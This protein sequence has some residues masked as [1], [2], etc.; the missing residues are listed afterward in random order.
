MTLLVNEQF[1]HQ[2]GG[3]FIIRFDDTTPPLPAKQ[4]EEIRLN[5]KETIEWLGIPVDEWEIESDILSDV[6]DALTKLGHKYVNDFGYHDLPVYTRHIN[7]SWLAFP[8]VPQQTAERVVMDNMSGITHIIRGEEFALEFSLYRYYCDKFNFPH[9]KFI[10]LPR[11]IGKYGDISKTAGGYSIAELR[12]DGH[13][14]SDV[15]ELVEK[16]CLNWPPNGWSLYNL[17]REPRLNL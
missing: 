14:A 2:S 17:K 1:A 11:M 10:F 3:K 8:Y 6:R 15:I 12:G 4:I 7:T 5:Q 13:S 16:A 9:P